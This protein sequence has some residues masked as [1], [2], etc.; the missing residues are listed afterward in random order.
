MKYIEKL[1]REHFFPIT[2]INQVIQEPVF[3]P[4]KNITESIQSSRI[5]DGNGTVIVCRGYSPETAESTT[6]CV[7]YEILKTGYQIILSEE[8]EKETDTDYGILRAYW[9]ALQRLIKAKDKE[10]AQRLAMEAGEQWG[11]FKT[12]EMLGD[13]TDAG[14]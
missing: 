14:L 5:E 4:R 9:S 8:I 3:F 13:I 2:S 10:N 11:R 1:L 12:T 6:Y 7:D